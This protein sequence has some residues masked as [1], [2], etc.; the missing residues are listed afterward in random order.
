MSQVALDCNN[1]RNVE[2]YTIL[3]LC[4]NIVKELATM[5]SAVSL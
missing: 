1:L 3:P 5:Y 2:T 4:R